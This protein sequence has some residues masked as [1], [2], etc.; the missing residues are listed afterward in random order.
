[1]GKCEKCGFFDHRWRGVKFDPEQEVAN[2]DDVKHE[3][4]NKN[5]ISPGY[6]M[7]DKFVYCIMPRGKPLYVKRLPIEVYEARKTMLK[8][9]SN[10]DL[11][12]AL[13]G[14]PLLLTHKIWTVNI[15]NP[16][17]GTSRSTKQTNLKEWLHV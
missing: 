15:E 12:R 5:V 9:P 13:D 7:D 6:L 8:N 3:M 2:W 17:K 1:M 10:R 11:F 16:K 4:E 14:E